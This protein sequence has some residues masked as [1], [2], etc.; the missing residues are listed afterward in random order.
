MD[1]IL[2]I[3][4]KLPQIILP[5]DKNDYFLEWYNKDLRFQNEIPHT[6][7]RGY[8]FLNGLGFS[9]Q[10]ADIFLTPKLIKT[11]AHEKGTTYRNIEN[12]I[13]EFITLTEE[14]TVYFEFKNTLLCL[15]IYVSGYPN[16]TIT[17]DLSESNINPDVPN[18]KIED[19]IYQRFQNNEDFNE[20]YA[21]YCFIIL[22]T[23]LWYI[24]TSTKTSKYYRQDN[25]SSHPS[26]MY[27]KKTVVNV[28]RNKTITTPIYDM[29]KIKRVK[30]EGLIKRRKGWTYS[31]SF[32]VHG[33]YRHYK[34]GKVIFIKPFIKGKGKEEISQT[35]TLNPKEEK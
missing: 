35:I 11:F 10:K 3:N 27:E 16:K 5:K 13:K 4:K 15:E 28:K 14:T 26:Y 32:Q 18:P 2:K 24:A 33:H 34:S 21:Y 12:K 20:L 30:V 7:E 22:E 19:A 8:L 23:C 29:T 9:T 6:F 17:I 31:H 1:K 25:S